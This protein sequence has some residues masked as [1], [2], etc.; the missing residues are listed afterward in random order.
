[1]G[2]KPIIYFDGHYVSA[3]A[4]LMA[5]LTPGRHRKVGVFETLRAVDGKPEFFP[6]HA[7]RLQRGLR[8]LHIVRPWTNAALG[9][10]IRSTIRRN[11]PFPY[12]RVRVLVFKDRGK[13]HG[14]V[15]VQK[16][17]PP[18]QRQY[19]RGLRLKIIKT[20]KPATARWANVKSL[21]YRLFK[22]AMDQAQGQGYDD[23]FL[24][25]AKGH[26]FETTRANVFIILDGKLRTPPLSSGCL[27]GI[28]RRYVL[29]EAYRQRLPVVEEPLT[30]AML[31]QAQEVF[32]TNSL[33]GVIPVAR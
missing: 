5:D 20:K 14:A 15:T 22:N 11:P 17:L 21:D 7:Q 10:I 6:E 32:L 13:V 29:A 19:R 27:N 3:D 18:S 8:Q 1:M 16:Y 12:A 26:I 4:A 28:I 33:V 2:A 25:N 31:R 30:T 24:L 23:A 9:S